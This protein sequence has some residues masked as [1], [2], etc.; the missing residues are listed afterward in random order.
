M[1][2][3]RDNAPQPAICNIECEQAL[4][5]ALLLNNEVLD[6]IGF[7]APE[8]FYEPVHGRIFTQARDW[9][10]AGKLASPVTLKPV[11]AE[12]EGLQEL[13]GTDY[14]AR[15]AGATISIVAAPDYAEMVMELYSRRE[16][17]TAAESAIAI[18]GAFTEDGGA[19]QAI[20]HLDGD[21]DAIRG[22]TQRR[23]PSV[24]F[25]TAMTSAMKRM[26]EARN[27]GAGTP[28]GIASLD[29]R[30]GGLYPGDLLYIA[31]RP[32]MGKTAV[33]ISMARRI[34]TRGRTVIFSSLEMQSEDLGIRM[35]SEALRERGR[36]I[37]YRDVRQGRVNDD[38][39]RIVMEVGRDMEALPIEIIESHVRR[40]PHL[41]SEIRRL[42]RRARTKGQEI[43]AIFIDYLGLIEL[44]VPNDNSRVSQISATLK[45]MAGEHKVPVV[46]LAQLNRQVENR[47]DK[48]P[49]LADLRDS[50]SLEQDADTVIFCYRDEYYR[51]R[52]EPDPKAIERHSAWLV[53]MDSCRGKMDLIIAKQRM[54][55]VGTVALECDLATNSIWDTAP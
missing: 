10:Q 4:L 31:G 8:H 33:A 42:V 34:A 2:M 26:L 51:E 39:A 45:G 7:I 23:A 53:N 46:V 9:I 52:M 49:R 29:N 44:N 19:A 12:D 1:T 48:R 36:N 17:I 32:S 50:G 11:L 13:G 22:N 41:Q 30:I 20:E 55:P 14:L 18:A 16:V 5:G 27:H 6:Q 40:L 25:A 37:P 24:S 35:A 38:E 43:G 3:P 54:G 21:L 28:T 47:D 15:L